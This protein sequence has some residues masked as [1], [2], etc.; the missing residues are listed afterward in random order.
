MPVTLAELSTLTATQLSGDGSCVIDSVD[1]IKRAGQGAIAFVSDLRY[2]KYLDTTAASAVI[3]TPELVTDCKAPALVADNPRLVYA[4]IANILYP[5]PVYAAGK[6]GQAIIDATATVSDTACISA[7]A[8]IAANA[9][10]GDDTYIGPGAVIEHDAVI[11]N[12]SI[13]HAN[14]TVGHDCR[15]G[16]NCIL[17]SGCVLGADGFGFIRDGDENIK[18]PQVGA[19]V[20][21]NDVEVGACTSIDRGALEDTV[22]GDGVKLD[23]QI[24]VAHSVQ[25]GNNTIISAATAIAGSTKIGKNCLIGGLTGIREHIEIADNVMITART[26]VTHS[27]TCAGSSY[28][29][30]TPMDETT[31]WRKNSARFRQLDKMARRIAALEKAL[32]QKQNK[33]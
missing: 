31:S 20:L 13:I 5:P 28:S 29:S 33:D 21:G 7:G 11:G 8:V 24:Q 15:V 14:A 16:D 10:I 2:K 17:H 22:L 4:K 27:I 19:V 3:V 30:S 25:I 23:N 18:I 26:L 32:Q 12:G 6:S 9:S 1:D